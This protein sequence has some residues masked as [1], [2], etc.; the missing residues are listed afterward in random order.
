MPR[1][2]LD[3][4]N[5]ASYQVRQTVLSEFRAA[6]DDVQRED[7][8]QLLQSSY[9]DVREGVLDVLSA[10]KLQSEDAWLSAITAHCPS[11]PDQKPIL[12]IG[13]LALLAR[14]EAVSDPALMRFGETCLASGMA[15][16]QYQA[17]F[18]LE[19]HND[20]SDAYKDALPGL[21]EAADE[22]VR[23]IAV[24][25]VARLAPDW[26]AKK[27]ADHAQHAR[28]LEAFHTLLA[29]LS[30]GDAATR[31][32]LEDELIRHLYDDRFCYPAILALKQYG[33][34]QAVEHLL[35]I[36]GSFFGEPTIRIVAAD[37]AAKLGSP[38]AITWLRK[39]AKKSGNPEYARQVL[40]AYD[41][42]HSEG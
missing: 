7:F 15:D 5:H 14:F 6:A 18:F 10:Q 32:T 11:S 39:F 36:A 35:R 4:M 31:Q 26:G 16:L 30:L 29:R 21:L 37:A 2:I 3:R 13:L 33:S 8:A 22:D 17:I 34:A 41:A 20:E 9:K 12:S 42:V 1:A 24:Q 40:A 19:M 27:L 38:E 25:A 23:I 28:G